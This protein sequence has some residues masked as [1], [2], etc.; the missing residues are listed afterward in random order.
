MILITGASGKTGR[1]VVGKLAGSGQTVCALVRRPE[2]REALLQSG[3]NE[4]IVGDL[5]SQADLALATRGVTAIYHICPNMHPGEVGIGQSLIEAARS[6]GVRRIVYHSVLHPQTQ[7]M[8]HHWN[9]L[10]VEEL[11]F[12]SGLEF[13]ILQPCAYMQNVLA[14]RKSIVD[15][16]RYR[17]PYAIETRIGM[18]D[19]NDVAEVAA[20]VLTEAGHSGAIYELASSEA[21]SQSE[22][23]QILSETLGRPVQAE[24]QDRSEWEANA[25]STGLSDY[26]IDTLLRMFLYYERY[27]FEGNAQVLEMLLG[28]KTAT[29]AEWAQQNFVTPY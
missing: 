15:E 21:L 27:G 2:Q 23:A 1:A 9:K 6:N 22:V 10:R 19:L 3:V 5:A 18:V 7:A 16:G 20:K 4:V 28:R 17:V 26:A 12:E 13:T 24:A 11:L 25:R 8:P 14:Y 29:F